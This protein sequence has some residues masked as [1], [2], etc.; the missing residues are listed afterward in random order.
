[1]RWEAIKRCCIRL[2]ERER[3]MEMKKMDQKSKLEQLFILVMIGVACLALFALTGCGGNSCETVHCNS[4]SFE[5]G[6]AEG[7]SVPSCGG[8][9][10]CNSGCNSCLWAQ[11]CKYVSFKESSDDDHS[12]KGGGCDVR[13]LGTSCLGCGADEKSCYSGCIQNKGAAGT[14]TSVFYGD[15]DNGGH[16]LRVGGGQTGCVEGGYNQF[17]ELRRYE[18][19]IGID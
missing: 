9:L 5:G 11:S 6:T 2:H 15:T 8:C 7:C 1:M 16:I 12:S 18:Q 3:D 17:S 13:Y 10:G 4:V 19:G 14:T